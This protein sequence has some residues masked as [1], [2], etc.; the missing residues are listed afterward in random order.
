MV[1]T[2]PDT[3][4]TEFPTENAGGLCPRGAVLGRLLGDRRRLLF[5]QVKRGGRRVEVRLEEAV[6][7][8]L[9]A[10]QDRGV[11]FFLDANV[12]LEEIMAAS[13]WCKAWPDAKLCMVTEPADEAALL[14]AEASGAEY[15]KADALSQCDGY[16]MIGD[17]FAAN[18][19]RARG[20]FDRRAEQPRTP[21]VVIDPARGSS[22]KFATH[23]VP[24]PPGGELAALTGVAAG[25]GLRLKGEALAAGKAIAACER[26]GVLIAPE[27]G[28]TNA[29][30]NIG[31]LAG[32]LAQAK[33]GVISVETVGANALAAVRLRET[34][35][36]ITLADALADEKPLR[37]AL[38]CDVNG[39]LGRTD[40]AF[41]AAG[42]P[43]ENAT[44]E[45]A[46]LV[47]PTPLAGEMTG[48]FFTAEGLTRVPALLAPPAGVP[49][50]G[51]II[52][53]MAAAAGA[54]APTVAPAP[55]AL[56]R[57]KADVPA[58]APAAA[59]PQAPVMLVGRMAMN[60]SSG[61][62]TRYGTWQENIQ[63]IP[64]VRMSA[65][66]AAAAGIR[67]ESEM[68]VCVG[69]KS[70]RGR[71]LVLPELPGGV[72]IVSDGFAEVR[73]LAPAVIDR[74]RKAVYSLPP[75]V[76]IHG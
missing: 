9:K 68:T 11:T 55:E 1:E 59:A 17:V 26:L 16:V 33:G 29:W 43:F 35:G 57:L 69:D 3:W 65:E 18:P 13:A 72:V 60:A 64:D 20:V 54:A 61:S 53:N 41:F 28:R 45:A 48:T 34:L 67:N 12:P 44:T 24:T 56:K 25:A 8:V 19:T 21:I 63:R 38:G 74:E 31:Y 47:L 52:A 62:I 5:P 2:G 70:V 58:E 71:A 14:G 6:A 32:Q 15:L 66:D 4:R 39:M 37:V 10:A 51:K 30:A 22:A 36:A 46:E 7:A 27:Y 76:S 73:A 49:S 42:A 75:R 50:P 40:L 23:P